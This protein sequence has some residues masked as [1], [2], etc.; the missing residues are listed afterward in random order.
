[1]NILQ[2][3]IMFLDFK[4]FLKANIFNVKKDKLS[5]NKLSDMNSQFISK[6]FDEI[7][8][9]IDSKENLSLKK[10]GNE[11]YL[12]KKKKKSI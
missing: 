10:I 6:R 5:S 11:L 4:S 1:M 3:I 9:F 2:Y 8:K 7:S 12:I